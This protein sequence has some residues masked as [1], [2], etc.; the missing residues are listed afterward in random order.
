M[1]GVYI[2]YTLGAVDKIEDSLFGRIS[3]K[4]VF[5]N[6][7]LQLLNLAPIRE[8]PDPFRLISLWRR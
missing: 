5:W 1:K 6:S 8:V 3:E 2:F 7:L 4:A